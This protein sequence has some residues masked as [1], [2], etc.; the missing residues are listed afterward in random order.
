MSTNAGFLCA[1]LLTRYQI[2]SG[3]DASLFA[4]NTTTGQL[5]VA[6]G[7][8]YVSLPAGQKYYQLL[9]RVTDVGGLYAFTTVNVTV[10]PVNHAPLTTNYTL[11]VFEEV[12]VGTAIPVAVIA[13]DPDVEPV[14]FAIVGVS[15]A[16]AGVFALSPPFAADGS[17]YNDA[18]YVTVN[19]SI[20]YE[21]LASVG[22]QYTLSC[23][24]YDAVTYSSFWVKVCCNAVA[25]GS[26]CAPRVLAVSPVAA[27]SVWRAHLTY[28]CMYVGVCVCNPVAI[29]ACAGKRAERQRPTHRQPGDRVFSA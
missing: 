19:A 11:S 23:R 13:Y 14:T 28:M 3:N 16:G 24:A 27:S 20:K 25:I 10:T 21:P 4:I 1:P 29:D 12:A 22:F 2:D 15:S 8:S 5:R 18:V 7:L 26:L 17:R 6:A 9:V